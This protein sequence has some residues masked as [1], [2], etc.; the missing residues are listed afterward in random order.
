MFRH[1]SNQPPVFEINES[2][3]RCSGCP[4]EVIRQLYL[5]LS[6]VAV[7]HG[8]RYFGYPSFA[9]SPHAAPNSSSSLVK[10]TVHR[11]VEG[12][13]VSKVFERCPEV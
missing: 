5:D 2:P 7:A 12:D 3:G 6:V 10:P 13:T 4:T 9:A 8:V 1:S 11:G